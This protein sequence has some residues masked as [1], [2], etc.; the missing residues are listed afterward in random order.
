MGR[1][2]RL[3]T[4]SEAEQRDGA[5][6]VVDRIEATGSIPSRWLP[7]ETVEEKKKKN[8][9]RH[10]IPPRLVAAIEDRTNRFGITNSIKG[11]LGRAS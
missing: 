3:L 4:R 9:A 10:A 8:E 2:I 1:R 5:G 6:P 11:Y 7:F